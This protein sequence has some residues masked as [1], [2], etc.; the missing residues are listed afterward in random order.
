V[1]RTFPLVNFGRN[2]GF[3]R[4]VA[5]NLGR[6][7]LVVACSWNCKISECEDTVKGLGAEI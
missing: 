6:S 4:P 5:C 7:V 2:D 3:R 1:P